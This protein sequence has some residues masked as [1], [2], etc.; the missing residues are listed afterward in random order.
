MTKYYRLD[1]L[2]I[3]AC[4]NFLAQNRFADVSYCYSAQEC[5]VLGDI[6]IFAKANLICGFFYLI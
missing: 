1:I 5:E 2:K 3:I 4:E 6:L